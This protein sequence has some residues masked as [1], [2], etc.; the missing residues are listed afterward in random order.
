MTMFY[1]LRFTALILLGLLIYGQTFNYDF[2]F[3]DHLFIVT[4]PFIKNFSN[5]HVMWHAFP[6]TRFVPMCTF[7]LNYYF[8]Q[9]HPQGYHIFNFIVHLVATGLVWALAGLL[10]RITKSSEDPFTKELPFII[11]VLFLVHPC[12]TQAVSYISQRFESMATV[13][14]LA[15]VYLYLRARLSTVRIQQ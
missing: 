15:T 9:L 3:D 4:N 7:A 6:L 13:F 2:V 12:Q 8:N 11:A 1:F 14:Y 5:F 10:F